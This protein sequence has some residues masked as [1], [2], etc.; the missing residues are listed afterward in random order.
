MICSFLIKFLFHGLKT[1]KTNKS[2]IENYRNRKIKD[3]IVGDKVYSKNIEANAK[4]LNTVTRVFKNESLYIVHITVNNEEICCTLEHPFWIVNSG[5]AAAKDIQAEDIIETYYG[6]CA[7]VSEILIDELTENVDIYNIEVEEASTYYVSELNLLVHNG[8]SVSEEGIHSNPEKVSY[9]EN[10][11]EIR[12]AMLNSIP[13]NTNKDI[14]WNEFQGIVKGPT[15]I[16]A[17]VYYEYTGKTKAVKG[18]N[19]ADFTNIDSGKA[20]EK[21]AIHAFKKCDVTITPSKVGANNGFDQVAVLTKDGMKLRNS[22]G[23]INIDSI[24]EIIINESKYNTAHIGTAKCGTEDQHFK[25]LSDEWIE[26]NLG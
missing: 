26:F 13:K 15:D 21:A 3:I 11:E 16:K 24:Q 20:G 5:W 19:L 22:N 18:I 6:E 2:R 12:M 25:Q 4:E 17:D 23:K 1:F 7:Y 9:S 8:C 14:T 10:N